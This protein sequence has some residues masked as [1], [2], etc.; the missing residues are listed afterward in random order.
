VRGLRRKHPDQ[1][2]EVWAEDEGRLGLQPITRRVWSLRGR[3]P[4]SYGQARYQWMYVYGFVQPKTG[5]SFQVF[6]PRV[7]TELMSQALAEFSAWADPGRDKILLLIVDNAGWHRS[8]SLVVPSNVLLHRLPPATPELQPVEP[9]W[10]LIRET[11][12]NRGFRYIGHLR[13][14]VR[15]RCQWLARHPETVRGRVGFAWAMRL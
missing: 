15:R 8:K 7:K 10:S 14:A 12:A 3:R 11:V 6:L 2:V 5:R 9:Y 4:R 1:T 13:M